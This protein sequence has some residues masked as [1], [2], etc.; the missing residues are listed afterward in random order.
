MAHTRPDDEGSQFFVTTG[1]SG[2]LDGQY[3]V[4]GRVLEGQDVVDRIVAGDKIEKVEVVRTRSHEYRPTTVAGT[5]APE[6]KVQ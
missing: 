6:P 3:T 5:P 4:F 1:A 2:H